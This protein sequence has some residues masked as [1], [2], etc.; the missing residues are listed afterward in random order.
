MRNYLGNDPQT[1]WG[2]VTSIL[3]VIIS[4]ISVKTMAHVF[5]KMSNVKK[6]SYFAHSLTDKGIRFFHIFE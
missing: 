2:V 3:R 5:S 6:N 4:F 1:P